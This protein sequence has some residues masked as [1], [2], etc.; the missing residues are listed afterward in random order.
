MKSQCNRRQQRRLQIFQKKF[1]IQ[2]L[3]HKHK[4]V[5]LTVQKLLND[6]TLD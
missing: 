5:D 3:E 6:M 4:V 2:S 1:Y